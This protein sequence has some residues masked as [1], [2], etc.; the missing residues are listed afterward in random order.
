MVKRKGIVSSV[1]V[2]AVVIIVLTIYD[3]IGTK[4]VENLMWEYLDDKGYTQSEIQSVEV[5]HSF[6]N[7]ILSYNECNIVVVYKD[8]PT[9]KYS[10]HLKAGNII[11]GGVSG[12]T[13]KDNLKH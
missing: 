2:V 5:S 8:E 7:I 11:E 12:T 13:E 10:Y 6:L 1:C 3:F 9:S 4:R